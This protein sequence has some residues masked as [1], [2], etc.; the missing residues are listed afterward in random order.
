MKFNTIRSK[1]TIMIILSSIL[2]IA[3]VGTVNIIESKKA[4]EQKARQ[5]SYI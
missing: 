5:S 3:I 2:L 4:I 1:L